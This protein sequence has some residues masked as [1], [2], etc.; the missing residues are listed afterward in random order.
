[1]EHQKCFEPALASAN[2]EPKNDLLGSG[3]VV[4]QDTKTPESQA[5]FS[6]AAQSDARATEQDDA[7]DFEKVAKLVEAGMAIL[8]LVGKVPHKILAPHGVHSATTDLARIDHWL[9]IG[10]NL[11]ATSPDGRIL[12]IDIDPRHGGDMRS[13]LLPRSWGWRTG[14][15]DGGVHILYRVPPGM[16]PGNASLG[17]GIDILGPGK[18][19]VIPPSIHP[20]TGG[21]YCWGKG[22]SP[23]ERE[24]TEVPPHIL[25]RLRGRDNA[26]P[27]DFGDDNVCLDEVISAL[28]YVD[29]GPREIWVR[30]GIILKRALDEDTGWALFDRWSKGASNYNE[31][32]NRKDWNSFGR[33][34]RANRV[35]VGTIF[36]LARKAGW[37]GWMPPDT[38]VYSDAMV[39][40]YVALH[41]G[42]HAH[43]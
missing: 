7:P 16:P 38:P 8:P 25:E 41:E 17:A 5:E 18:Y 2:G 20:D 29:N 36:F 23:L 39:A 33:R 31:L 43:E 22:C 12:Y 40:E 11:G 9:R 42:G 34:G 37:P 30:V 32:R 4:T 15:G 10:L 21:P 19:G 6:D 26:R 28:P 1:M 14:R 24:L 35:G 13:L 3:I 27:E